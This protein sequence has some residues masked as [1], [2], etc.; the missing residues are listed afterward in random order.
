MEL[1]LRGVTVTQVPLP[2][3]AS[4]FIG[5]VA[6]G[7]IASDAGWRALRHLAV[8][9]HEGA[10]A[11]TGTLLFRDF[12]GIT[13][14]SDATGAT[15]IR[16]DGS[17]GDII[18]TFSGYVGPS[19]F[20]IG[21]AKLIEL[22]H[23]VAALWLA[24]FLLAL[25]LLGLR[26]SFGRL[27]VIVAGGLVFFIGRYTPTLAQVIAAY[28]VAWLLLLSGVRRVIEVSTTSSDGAYLRDL[29]HLPRFLWFL[30]WLAG[31]LAAVAVGGRLLIT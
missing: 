12:R 29:T 5:L 31:T 28:T 10:H 26:A 20:G 8:M 14:N 6:L 19:M 16:L 15:Y 22:G 9:A 23:I 7:V 18:I 30:L 21:A 13:L 11:V 24:L 17:P 3:V 25:L 1:T 2:S 4:A 27:T